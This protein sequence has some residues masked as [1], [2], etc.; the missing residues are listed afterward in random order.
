MTRGTVLLYHAFGQRDS[1]T[2]PH[3]LFVPVEE[4]RWQLESLLDRGWHPLTVD[5]Y[6]AGLPARSW[7]PRTFLLTIDDGHASTVEAVPVLAEL[8]IPFLLFIPPAV[9][10]GVSAWMPLMPASPMMSETDLL[11]VGRS[12]GAEIGAHGWDHADLPGMSPAVL[13]R[14]VVDCA[15][16]LERLLGVRPRTYAYPRGL[17]DAAAQR[18]V[19][20][21]GYSVAFSTQRADGQFAVPRLDV[22]AADTRRTFRLKTSTAWPAIKATSGHFPRLRAAA[23]RLVGHARA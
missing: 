8:D 19:A 22:N 6:L 12:A 21:A 18:A 13:R 3:N 14:N 1:T 15:D 10:G 17:F 20:A 23:H 5:A 2:D 9:V 7:A 11:D 4:F 16:E